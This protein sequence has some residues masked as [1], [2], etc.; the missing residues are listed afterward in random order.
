MTY[1]LGKPGEL[2]P[3]TGDICTNGMHKPMVLLKNSTRAFV[4]SDIQGLTIHDTRG[5][6]EF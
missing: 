5:P 4:N 1:T 6:R 2:G 3:D